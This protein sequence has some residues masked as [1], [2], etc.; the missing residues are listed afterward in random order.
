MGRLH[1]NQGE[2][3]RGSEVLYALCLQTWAQ[4]SVS[5]Y[6][7]LSSGSDAQ[8]SDEC[9]RTVRAHFHVGTWSRRADKTNAGAAKCETSKLSRRG[10]ERM[11]GC[12]PPLL[13]LPPPSLFTLALPPLDSPILPSTLLPPF[14]HSGPKTPT[15]LLPQSV[16]TDTHRDTH[17]HF[18]PPPPE[19]RDTHAH[20]HFHAPCQSETQVSRSHRHRRRERE[21]GKKMGG[22]V[23]RQSLYHSRPPLFPL[24]GRWNKEGQEKSVRGANGKAIGKEKRVEG[25]L[26]G[27]GCRG[28]L[29]CPHFLT[30]RPQQRAR[31]DTALGWRFF[32]RAS[33]RSLPP[34]PSE[35]TPP[36]T[37][38]R[39]FPV[40]LSALIVADWLNG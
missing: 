6:L 29:K 22:K 7:R 20:I 17:S 9:R 34:K 32:V 2:S 4:L 27:R 10:G 36:V 40:A 16:Q 12:A 37:P 13:L 15:I 38:P 11:S 24:S 14:T 3:L 1:G 35:V 33:L 28:E 8:R 23:A 18:A 26:E 19:H 30:G 39:L 25:L 21:D 5:V 31:R